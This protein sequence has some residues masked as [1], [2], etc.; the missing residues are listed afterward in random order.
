MCALGLSEPSVWKRSHRSRFSPRAWCLRA[1]IKVFDAGR[2]RRPAG[3]SFLLDILRLPKVC[4]AFFLL[5]F[6]AW[7]PECCFDI[8]TLHFHRV[9]LWCVRWGSN[10]I[11][12]L[13]MRPARRP[14]CWRMW[15]RTLILTLLI[16]RYEKESREI[17]SVEKGLLSL[18]NGSEK[19]AF[20]SRLGCPSCLL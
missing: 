7:T 14:I 8:R 20:A 2:P 11:F 15:T 1:P 19:I 3:V 13:C 16:R 10:F 4:T 6:Y 18:T 5:L 12:A 9:R 17:R